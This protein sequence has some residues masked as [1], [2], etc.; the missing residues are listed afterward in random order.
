M[1]TEYI[2]GIVISLVLIVIIFQYFQISK[3]TKNISTINGK[4]D[5]TSWTETEKMNYEH[6]GIIPARSSRNTQTSKIDTK[7]WTEQE[8]MMYEHHGTI[9]NK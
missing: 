2:L 5:M 7:G 3:L 6:H 8:K 1:K 9:P 4:I